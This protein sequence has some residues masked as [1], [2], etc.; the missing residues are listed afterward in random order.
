MAT[1]FASSLRQNA[2]KKLD[3][4]NR[5]VYIIAK[6]L[7][8]RVVELSPSPDNPGEYAKGWLANQWYPEA[9]DFSE[10][11]SG[12]TSDN[13]SASLGRIHAMSGLEF[14]GRDGK[15]TLTNNL[16]YAYRAETLGWPQPLWSGKSSH[17]SS[18]YHMVSLALQE[19]AALYR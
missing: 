9:G 7:F 4:A 11:L 8:A 16:H 10:E 17:A 19:I 18:G 1:G 12:A 14:F 15:L 13:G 6:V 3:W 2:W 5:R